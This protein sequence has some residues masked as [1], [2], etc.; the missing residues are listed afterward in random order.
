M[1]DEAH[2]TGI[3]G[4]GGRG[5]AEHFNVEGK[6]DI[7][8]GTLSKALGSQGG[9]V[10]GSKE[11]IS[12]LVNKSR[13][14]IYTTALA[15][16]AAAASLAA[17]EAVENEPERRIKLLE[18]SRSLKERFASMGFDTC[19]SESQIVPLMVGPVTET[20][21]LAAKLW[22]DG[23]FAPAIRP[24]TVPEGMSRLRFSLTSDHTPEDVNKLFESITA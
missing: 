6:I 16:A 7:I 9:F 2:A 5:C 1:I 14:F 19:G 13:S 18:M 20:V 12:Y 15:P 17:I 8:M 4:A 23:I 21:S 3:F 24:P 11:L 10:C 22:A